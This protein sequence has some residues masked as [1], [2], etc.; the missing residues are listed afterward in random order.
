MVVDRNNLS[1]HHETLGLRLN[2]YSYGLIILHG[3]AM[4]AGLP[5]VLKGL[6]I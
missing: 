3:H 6:R 5:L 4:R 2:A 1:Y